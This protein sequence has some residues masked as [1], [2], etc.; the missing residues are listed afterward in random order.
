MGLNRISWKH[1]FYDELYITIYTLPMGLNRISWKLHRVSHVNLYCALPMGLN[2][3]SWKLLYSFLHYP[4][5]YSL[6]M[7]LNRISWKQL[8]AV[9]WKFIFFPTDGFKSD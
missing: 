9:I 6:P 2:R 4:S 1:H 5:N 8:F 7:G 3:I